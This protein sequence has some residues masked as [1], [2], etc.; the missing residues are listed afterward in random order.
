VLTG[1][2]GRFAGAIGGGTAEGGADFNAGR[3]AMDLTG[4]LAL[5]RG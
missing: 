5:P 4:T 3:F 2:T 1:G